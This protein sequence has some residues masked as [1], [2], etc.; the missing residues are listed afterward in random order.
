MTQPQ[1]LQVDIGDVLAVWTTATQPADVAIRL[2]GVI[3][4]ETGL[5][6]HVV[7]VH[8][9][10]DGVWWGLEG[11][12]GGVGWVDL[13][14][15]IAHP[16]TT[17]NAAQPKTPEQ[18]Q[19][20]AKTVEVMLGTPYDWAA[21]ADDGLAALHLPHLFGE[22]W[23]GQGVPGHVVCSSLAAY[24]YKANGMPHPTI[25]T[26]RLTTPADWTDWNLGKRWTAA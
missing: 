6:N 16:Y 4:G 24:G 3:A 14:R 5:N 12:P 17:S 21:I 8:H 13:T 2:G 22:N 11:K 19:A 20:I 1:T 23:D 10:T 7:V 25:H 26:E 18:R 15:D 9:L